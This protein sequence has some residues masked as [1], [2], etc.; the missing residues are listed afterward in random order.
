MSYTMVIA[1]V[2][3]VPSFLPAKSKNVLGG[4]LEL[5]C[6]DPVTGFA[7][8]GEGAAAASTAGCPSEYSSAGSA[9]KALP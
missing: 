4:E 1:H 3:R 6:T 5:C 9:M 2:V 8:D 7:R